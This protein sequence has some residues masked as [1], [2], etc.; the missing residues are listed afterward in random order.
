M[1]TKN[2]AMLIRLGFTPSSLLKRSTWNKVQRV[3]NWLVEKNLVITTIGEV[4]YSLP[5]GT[6]VT[7]RVVEKLTKAYMGSPI[8][9][10]MNELKA[11]ATENGIKINN[12]K[13]ITKFCNL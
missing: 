13:V 3:M 1:N 4:K 7:D 2:I 12:G 5:N 8:W 9:E 6:P 10:H 11:I